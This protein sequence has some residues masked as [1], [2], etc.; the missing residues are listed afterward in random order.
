MRRAIISLTIICLLAVMPSL[1][2]LSLARAKEKHPQKARAAANQPTVN[3]GWPRH[4]TTP[5]GAS[6]IVHQPQV[7][8]WENQKHMVALAAVSYLASGAKKPSLGTIKIEAETEVSITSRLVNFAPLKITEAN[9]QSLSKEQTQELITE[10]V[11]TIPERERVINLD[12]VLAQVDKSKIKSRDAEGIKADPPLIFFSQSPALLVGIDGDPIW[13]PIKN[14]DLKFAVNTNWDLFSHDP[15]SSF[16]LRND[17]M[18]FKA[19][20]M[21]GPWTRADHL[22]ASFYTLPAEENWKD[23]KANLP[24]KKIK[25]VPMVIVSTQPSEMILL[26]GEPKYVPVKG[27]NLLWVSN[28]E[29]DLFRLNENGPIY[30]LVAG[31]WFT[32]PTFDGPWTFAT[33]SLPP[34]FKKISL[35]HPR[36]RVLASVPGTDQAAEAVMLAQIPQTARVNK[37]ELKAPEVAYNGEPEYQPIEG[38]SLQRAVNTDKAII[39]VG[40][41]YYMCFEGVWFMSSSP[42]GP[43]EVASS[44]PDQIYEIPAGSP[45]YQ[46]TYVE[47]EEDDDAA[48]DWVTFAATAGY[49]GM[50]TAWGC[51]VW[52][53]GWYYPPYVGW[54]GYYPIY[55]PTW[56]TYGSAAWYNPYTGVYGTAGRIYGPYGGVGYGARYNPSTGTYARGAAAWGPYGARGAAQAYNPYTGAYAQTRQGAGIYGSWG[57]TYV[58]RGDDWAHTKRFSNRAT[59]TTT[60]VTRTDEGAAI[61][62]RG[63]EDK[64]FVAKG[65]N[66]IYAGRDG[67]VYRKDSSGNWQKFENGQWNP[68]QGAQPKN[69]TPFSQVRDRAGRADTKPVDRSTYQGLE[70][71]YSSRREGAKRSRDYNNYS[72][73]GG[74]YAGSYRGGG[75]RGGG[76]RRR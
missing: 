22:P 58:Q 30:Y 73:R 74:G 32:A 44:V 27:T 51:E 29:S 69:Q 63:P 57:S 37:K 68:I 54:G 8:D 10:I 55:Y 14:N 76:F 66:N 65:E 46:V 3:I 48:D 18:W 23:V 56:R 16:Y 24:G 52:G 12:Q 1:S 72:N 21:S 61:R 25:I 9:F 45:A 60:R 40:D 39:K 41:L 36:S 2:H 67:N 33:T 38:T 71:D 75:F 42:D 31:R 59:D 4:Y 62:R 70:R 5:S 17:D 53:T 49:I 50:M 15:T 28:T 19:S 6:I 34:D 47:V 7:A 13:S 26:D 35:E 64:G 20:R 11:K 43:W